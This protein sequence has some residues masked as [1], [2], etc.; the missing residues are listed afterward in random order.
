MS[1]FATK[2]KRS[3]GGFGDAIIKHMG[4]SPAS[5]AKPQPVMAGA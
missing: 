1:Q 4:G 2:L 3:T 5:A